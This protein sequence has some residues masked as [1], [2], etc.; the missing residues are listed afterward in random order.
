MNINYPRYAGVLLH[1]TSL[2]GKYGIGTLGQSAYDFVSVLKQTGATL[3][4]ILP[5]GPTGY[6]NSPYAAR[7]CFAG[8]EFLIDLE[9]L[10]Q[11]GYLTD[12]DLA[13]CPNFDDK[14]VDFSKI[15][16]WKLPLLKKAAKNFFET[17]KNSKDFND[18]VEN[19]E[20]W[21][22]DYA[23]FMVFYSKYN[24]ARWYS[25]WD[26]QIA[27]R[28]NTFLKRAFI[29]N[30]EEI[31]IWYSLQYLF[32]EQYQNLKTFANNKGIKI[33][34]DIP[35]FVGADSVDTWANLELFKTNYDGTFSA[36]S[37]VPPDNFCA[38]GQ[39]WG[40][41]VYDWEKHKST[42]YQWWINRIKRQLKLADILRID[43]FRGFDAYYEIKAGSP[44]AEFGTWQKAQGKELFS[45]LRKEFNNLPIIAEDL[46]F[47]TDSVINLRISNNFPGMKICQFG[48]S[49]D[50]NGNLNPCDTFLP[51]NIERDFVVYPGTH[52]NETTK[53]WYNNLNDKEKHIVREYLCCDDSSV[54]WELIKSIMLCHADYAIIPMQDLLEKGNEARMNTPSTCND[55]NWSW[56][57]TESDFLSFEVERFKHLVKISGRT[58][59]IS[60]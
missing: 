22:R 38:T 16:K 25:V 20:Y 56:R 23:L 50:E 44:T 34:G 36:V 39:L 3:W 53:G 14:K 54:L 29:D 47:L 35:I 52:D 60:S 9:L 46:G 57:M 30:K 45:I 6:G 31:N 18:F 32:N 19:E 24:D 4:Q 1:L 11:Q 48:F 10:Q 5:V 28:D 8:N 40:N 17:N 33:I 41:P 43:H 13:S 49:E 51:H 12:S 7:S 55:I 59:E 15:E 42:N 58:G 26:K 21:L 2:P 37:G 27:K